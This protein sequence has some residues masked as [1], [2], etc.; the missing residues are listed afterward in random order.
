MLKLTVP[1]PERADEISILERHAAGFDPRDLAAAG[2]GRVA[3]PAD[4]AQAR[5]EARKGHPAAG[6]TGYIVGI[7]RATRTSPSLRVGGSP[8][9]AT[10]L[11]ATSRAR[12]WV[13]RPGHGPP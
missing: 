13:S 2:I 12:A 5:G 3:G 10:P 7:C 11:L 4:L 1:L 8:R 6:V 9:G